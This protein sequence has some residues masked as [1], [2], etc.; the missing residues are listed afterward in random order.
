MH[1]HNP[2]M[3]FCTHRFN[4]SW[5]EYSKYGTYTMYICKKCGKN[6]T[7]QNNEYIQKMS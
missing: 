4:V 1:F 5:Q 2:K 6:M 7:I 3:L